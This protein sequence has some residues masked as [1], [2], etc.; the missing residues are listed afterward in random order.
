MPFRRKRM[1]KVRKGKEGK[2]ALKKVNK[3][4]K[5]IER[6]RID[7]KISST[8]GTAGTIVPLSLTQPGSD[9]EADRIGNKISLS[10]IYFPYSIRM[11]TADDFVQMRVM[12]VLDK[13]VN[14]AT[15]ALADLLQFT[16]TE[17]NIVSPYNLDGALRFKVLYDKK[18]SLNQGARPNL[19]A[20]MYSPLNGILA[21]YSG[22]TAVIGGVENT[23]LFL[24]HISDEA[25][26]SPVILGQA[27]VRFRDA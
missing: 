21:R 25:T 3:L 26:N 5:A 4:M 24:V 18:H 12:I 7:T 9:G 16:A 1:F 8:S 6:K 20:K 14:G 10:S 19:T 22:A 27:R 2:L 23:G 17:E 13:Q 11:N 15:F